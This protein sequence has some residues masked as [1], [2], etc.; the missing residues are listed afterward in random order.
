MTQE[1]EQ[2]IKDLYYHGDTMYFS[3]R[4]ES[5]DGSDCHY[6]NINAS[7]I[8]TKKPILQTYFEI[9]NILN[10]ENGDEIKHTF[11]TDC[12]GCPTCGYGEETSHDITLKFW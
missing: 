10:C 5:H 12:S 8:R 3:C 1:Q 2:Q 6:I 7:T 9:A 4:T 11:V